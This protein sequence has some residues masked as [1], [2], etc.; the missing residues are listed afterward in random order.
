MDL[1]SL[2]RSFSA[3]SD[4]VRL[5]LLTVL[6]TRPATCSKE[7]A[8]LLGIS[9]ALASH[10]TKILEDAALIVRRREGQ[11]S[12]FSLNAD[13]LAAIADALGAAACRDG[14]S[15]PA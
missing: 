14:D 7:L 11:F 1:C 10:H 15:P 2:A 9:V 13:Q 5:R 4:P 12:R 3:L 8:E 6:R